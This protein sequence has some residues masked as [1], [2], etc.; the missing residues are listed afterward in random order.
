VL[1]ETQSSGRWEGA[2]TVARTSSGRRTRG[3]LTTIL[4]H[5]PQDGS[6]RWIAA[7]FRPAG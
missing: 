6:P 2:F 5:D 1:P 3:R 4:V 7:I